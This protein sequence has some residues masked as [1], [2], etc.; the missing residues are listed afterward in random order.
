MA[1]QQHIN[2]STGITDSLMITPNG[3]GGLYYA[4]EGNTATANQFYLT[5][6]TKHFFK[7]RLIF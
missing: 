7:R 3:V 5:D 1:T 6:S 4:L 2:I